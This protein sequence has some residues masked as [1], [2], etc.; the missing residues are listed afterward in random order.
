MA[1]VN[2]Q[3]SPEEWKKSMDA[4][5]KK[6][7]DSHGSIPLMIGNS[8]VKREYSYT[9][10]CNSNVMDMRTLKSA[11][12]STGRNLVS[13]PDPILDDSNYAFSL[14]NNR[15]VRVVF[16]KDDVY[17]ILRDAYSKRLED[18]EYIKKKKKLEELNKFIDQH[19]PTES[20]LKKAIEEANELQKEIGE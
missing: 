8:G 5:V 17:H 3:A 16:T 13:V 6:L 4:A 10:L 11:L 1:K 19:E 2:F 15:G 14:T 9:D 20:K 18:S 12:I 7:I